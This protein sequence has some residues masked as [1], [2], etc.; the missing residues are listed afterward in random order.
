MMMLVHDLERGKFSPVAVIALAS[1]WP[2]L[3]AQ[4]SGYRRYD[5]TEQ[6]HVL[7]S[8]MEILKYL[9]MSMDGCFAGFYLYN[10]LT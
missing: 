10:R 8:C 1:F 4:N 2:R 6:T 3:Q 9:K 7:L 5:D